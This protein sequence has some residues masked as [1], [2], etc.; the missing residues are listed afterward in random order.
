[1][2]PAM[3]A[4]AAAGWFSAPMLIRLF[5]AN[6]DV[7]HYGIEF[8]QALIIAVPFLVL[9]FLVVGICQAIGRGFTSLVFA[10]L[11]KIIFEIPATVALNAAFGVSALAYG[12]FAAELVMSAIGTV[13]LLRIF[14]T[15]KASLTVPPLAGQQDAE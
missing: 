15:F 3:L 14:K 10:I 6:A 5:I 13:T 1:M 8:L 9:D 4:V 7:V 11:R 12:A 2:I